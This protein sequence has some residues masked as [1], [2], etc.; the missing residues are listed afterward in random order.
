MDLS[1]DQLIEIARSATQLEWLAAPAEGWADEIEKE[2]YEDCE[3]CR[4]EFLEECY[5]HVPEDHVPWHV[6]GPRRV[7]VDDFIFLGE[8]DARFMAAFDPK[9]VLELLQ[10]IKADASFEE[11]I[12]GRAS[13]VSRYSGGEN[14]DL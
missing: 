13:D 1:I 7:E 10:I 12:G 14:D 8:E 6:K 2:W 9:R 3:I 11:V 4:S 5:G